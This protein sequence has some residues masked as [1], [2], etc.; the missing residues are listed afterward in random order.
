MSNVLTV[1]TDV[2]TKTATLKIR[3]ETD[4]FFR[5]AALERKNNRKMTAALL[6]EAHR[7]D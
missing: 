5:V 4:A 7:N 3:R 2:M 1:I 6:M